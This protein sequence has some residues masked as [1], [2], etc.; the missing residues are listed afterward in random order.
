MESTVSDWIR[1]F[2]RL[3]LVVQCS[4]IVGLAVIG[5]DGLTLFFYAIFFSD[6]LALD[7]VLST[8]IAVI[9]GYP[10]AFVFLRQSVRLARMT[11]ELE[12]TATT[13]DLTQL[14]NRKAF[15]HRASEQIANPSG[16]GSAGILLFI[17][18]DHFKSL[19]DTCGHLAGDAVLAKLGAAIQACVREG[20]LAGRLGGEEFAVFLSPGGPDSAQNVCERIRENVATIPHELGL[21]ARRLTVSIGVAVH[22]SGQ[23]LE[24]LLRRADDNLYTAKFQGRDRIVYSPEPNLAA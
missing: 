23:A 11:D 14:L 3:P 24:E 12:R 20:D 10:L 15:L 22:R 17:D 13:D 21:P 4:I 8:V 18:V 6:R 19:N 7:L 5:T 16:D 9:V 1:R 2:W